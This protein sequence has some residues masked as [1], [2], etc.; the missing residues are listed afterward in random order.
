MPKLGDILRTSIL[1]RLKGSRNRMDQ[2]NFSKYSGDDMS[3]IISF[4]FKTLVFIASINMF[5]ENTTF[6]S[7]FGQDA[8]VFKEFFENKQNGIFIDIGAHD[9][10]SF[11][12]SKFFEKTLNWKGICI[13]PIPEVFQELKKKSK[14][15][16]HSRLY[17]CQKRQSSLHTIPQILQGHVQWTKRNIFFSS[18]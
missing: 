1:L 14:R 12:N 11:S 16:L 13:E 9:G 10:E 4:V 6:Y 15:Y 18:F 7:Q 3:M 2:L 8:F 17:L 5:G